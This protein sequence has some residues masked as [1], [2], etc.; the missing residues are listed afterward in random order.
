MKDYY[1]FDIIFPEIDFDAYLPVGSKVAK[2]HHAHLYSRENEI[3]LRIFHESNTYLGKKLGNWISNINLKKFGSY[4]EIKNVNTENVKEI[5]LSKSQ[6]TNLSVGGKQYEGNTEYVSIKLDSLRLK[7]EPY[8]DQLNSGEFYF[9][10]SGF[11]LVKGFY[12]PLWGWNGK[13]DISRMKGMNK[14]YSLKK[15]KFRPEFDF[16]TQDEKGKKEAIVLKAPK[17]QFRYKDGITENEALEYGDLIRIISSFYFHS[18]IDYIVS[19]IHLKQHTVVHKKIMPLGIEKGNPGLMG[20]GIGW[21]FDK[22]MKTRW[23][24]SLIQNQKKLS[25]VV[26]MFIQALQV[27][28]SSEYP[29]ISRQF[30]TSNPELR[31]KKQ[32]EA[33]ELLLETVK[34]QDHKDFKNKWNT[35]VGKLFTK[36]MLSPLSQFLE[37]QGLNPQNFPISVGKLKEMRDNISHGSIE[38]V[39]MDE[40]DRA[41]ILLYRITGILILNLL[42]IKKWKLDLQ[43][44]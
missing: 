33:L 9:N 29:A 31:K 28:N 38:K 36:P 35:S 5:D 44:K 12:A 19:K 20:F 32:K 16:G 11:K 2:I 1:C 15:S 42:G 6:L 22:F 18:N 39:N 27:D 4:F 34:S 24:R 13:F 21:D 3:E 14:F 30:A 26:D 37:K 8:E 10:E 17:L 40:L 41:N 23:Q 7:W 43:L 25:R